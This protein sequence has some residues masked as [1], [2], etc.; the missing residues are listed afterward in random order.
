MEIRRGLLL[1]GVTLAVLATGLLAFRLLRPEEEGQ[2]SQAS[3]VATAPQAGED[4]GGTVPPPATRSVAALGYIEPRG[5]VRRLAGA[6]N[7]PTSAR[8]AELLVSEGDAVV[9]GQA[10]AVFDG[11]PR[12]RAE[13][14]VL[15]AQIDSLARQLET[16]R[17]EEK[18]YADLV[19]TG[20]VSHD[21]LD[22][23]RRSTEKLAGDLAETKAELQ[24]VDADLRDGVLRAP[25]AG[26]VLRILTREGERPSD[27][28]VL[29]LGQTDF[30]EVVAE[31]YETDISQIRLGQWARITSEHGGFTGE[32]SGQ[33]REISRQ[34]NRRDVFSSDPADA[35]DARVVEV[36]IA[37]DPPAS[38]RVRNLTRMQ[39][40]VR[41]DTGSDLG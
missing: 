26:T 32:L 14:Q 16:S 12:L 5:Q 28:V 21:N 31:V 8:V 18:R 36:R 33:V 37:L 40:L 7:G 6:S 39:V 11:V 41:I 2:S 34:V 3:P 24:V 13:R 38:Q 17:S 1:I 30:M 20:A 23:R 35:V 25:M 15:Q 27:A 22:Q 10:L 4:A 9:Q 29:E 19:A